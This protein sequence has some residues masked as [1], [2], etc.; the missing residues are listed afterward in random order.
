MA[1]IKGNTLLKDPITLD[2]VIKIKQSLLGNDE[3][4]SEYL[5]DQ[6]FF[7]D[8]LKTLCDSDDAL[9]L[10]E[11]SIILYGYINFSDA[12]KQDLPDLKD[13]VHI[14]IRKCR[15]H[16]DILEEITVLVLSRLLASQTIPYLNIDDDLINVLKTSITNDN[17]SDRMIANCCMILISE[18][19]QMAADVKGGDL[20][21]KVISQ[22]YRPVMLRLSSLVSPIFIRVLKQNTTFSSF[23][24]FRK[25]FKDA[26]LSDEPPVL[27]YKAASTSARDNILALTSLLNSLAHFLSIL[28][29]HNHIILIPET[30][31]YTI[32]ALL[33]SS[34]AELR[35]AAAAVI[36]YYSAYHL[37]DKYVIKTN[38]DKVVPILMAN[39]RNDILSRGQRDDLQ[40]NSPRRNFVYTGPG[41][42]SSLNLLVKCCECQS[43]T[44]DK[45][46]GLGFVDWLM[47]S[48]VRYTKTIIQQE[49]D[50]NHL[51]DCLLLIS[52]ICA[53]DDSRREVVS[54]Y[55]INW[56][57]Y[58][59][60]YVEL[61]KR[62]LD[63]EDM[64]ISYKELSAFRLATKTVLS[65]CYVIRSMSRSAAVLRTSYE[66]K[67][68]VLNM[69]ELLKQ[70]FVMSSL[71]TVDDP[72]LSN[73]EV[74]LRSVILGAISN[75]AIGFSIIREYMD[76]KSVET[77]LQPYINGAYKNVNAQEKIIL[78]VSALQVIRNALYSDD[79]EFRKP[80]VTKEALRN[81]FKLCEHQDDRVKQ[82][83]FNIL[84]N[85]SAISIAQAENLNDIYISS[86]SLDPTH[87][88]D[89]LSFLHRHLNSTNDF[90][91]LTA[92]CYIFVNFASS[93]LDNQ[94][95]IMADKQ[96]L[97]RLHELLK[98]DIPSNS[99]KAEVIKLW[100]LKL[101]I[102]WIVT[103]LTWR[104][105]TAGSSSDDDNDSSMDVDN[106]S[107]ATGASLGPC[108]TA[109]ERAQKLI[110]IGFYDTIQKLSHNCDIADFRERA[111]T[112]VFQLVYHD[113]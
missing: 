101:S 40:P 28:G 59:S 9:L 68:V 77:A 108:S 70:P 37:E 55:P 79:A 74:L 30:L 97:E 66:L 17:S 88:T 56:N 78:L 33:R 27:L 15:S 91:T 29:R 35:Q 67:D 21:V 49:D 6:R 57:K 38:F 90:D 93:T 53:T 1:E 63:R 13:V 20:V 14:M 104:Q 94:K 7:P 16:P 43:S 95:K 100:N 47:L 58:I 8:I 83:S 3:L 36:V 48:L 107:A 11:C 54:K 73:D 31:I 86:T 25:V 10:R 84:R 4:K 111:R 99:P 69:F 52:C 5:K 102:V 71:A 75:F 42:L 50:T 98:L 19:T 24:S 105:G 89:F 80:F 41:R 12:W 76:S 45:L 26:S 106:A 85:V 62:I 46:V 110:K 81:V 113:E 92:I 103:N 72:V 96:L 87:D 60:S 32:Y 22:L 112:A 23:K 2:K 51:S 64:L 39:A 61:Y 34:S 82:Q 109:K 65:L 18:L 44:V